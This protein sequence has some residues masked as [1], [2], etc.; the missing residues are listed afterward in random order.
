[1]LLITHKLHEVREISSRVSVLRGGRLV[2]SGPTDATTEDELVQHL[3]G[4]PVSLHAGAGDVR[5]ARAPNA[6]TALR[7]ENLS[8]DAQGREALHAISL[9]V[10]SGEILGIAGVEGNGQQTLFDTLGG[11]RRASAGRIEMLGED[12]TLATPRR[13]RHL[14]LGRIPEDRH[15]TGL[16]LGLSVA[17]NLILRHYN[18]PPLSRRGWRRNGQVRARTR[19]LFRRFD[20]RAPGLRTPVRAL[21][22]GNQQKVVLA[23]ELHENPKLLIVANPVR[24]LDI[25]ATEYVYGQLR[26]QRDAGAAI[27]LISSDLE[28][29]LNLSDRVAVLYRGRLTSSV[30]ASEGRRDQIGSMMAGVA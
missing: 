29:I 14:S 19:D 27:L 11:I 6:A 4:R 25:G 21:S 18:D 23:R 13:L 22:G 7:V 8:V 3:V 24:G 15:A 28:E 16:M 26:R 2:F 5:P 12:T 20:I 30:V 1:M 9:Q 10:G 17:D